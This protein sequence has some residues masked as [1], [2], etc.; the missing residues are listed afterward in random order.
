MT[1][2]EYADHAKLMWKNLVPKNGHAATYNGE[3][4]RALE[5]LADEAQRNGN[6]N[7]DKRHSFKANFIRNTLINS[8]IFSSEIISEIKNDI[9]LILNYNFPEISNIVYDRLR[10]RIVDWDLKHPTLF[11]LSEE[12]LIDLAKHDDSAFLSSVNST[13]E[14]SPLSKA[15]LYQDIETVKSLIKAKTDLD[16]RNKFDGTALGE[17]AAVGNIEII[18]LLINARA[19]INHVDSIGQSILD[20]SKY[21]PE[22]KKFLKSIGAKSGKQLYKSHYKKE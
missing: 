10:N 18:K 16:A 19:N 20:M 1:E 4:L 14:D 22:A 9:D 21:R 3:L 15:I 5:S 11:E 2:K 13:E 7:W 12:F 17:A 8:T 6:K